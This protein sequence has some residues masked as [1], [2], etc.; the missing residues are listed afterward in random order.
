MTATY[1]VQNFV[2][3]NLLVINDLGRGAFFNVRNTTK[4]D[5]K[6]SVYVGAGSYY[7]V[8]SASETSVTKQSDRIAANL[9][10]YPALPTTSA[11]TGTIGLTF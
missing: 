8:Q 11:C 1:S 2:A 7:G 6:N 3:S 4:F 9:A 10:S 5:V